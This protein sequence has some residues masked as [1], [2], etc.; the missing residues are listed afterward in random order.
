M[1]YLDRKWAND[2]DAKKDSAAKTRPIA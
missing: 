2:I 1:G